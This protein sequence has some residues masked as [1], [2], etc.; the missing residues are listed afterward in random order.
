MRGSDMRPYRIHYTNEDGEKRV[1][2]IAETD[3]H[4][5]IVDFLLRTGNQRECITQ[6]DVEIHHKWV[7]VQ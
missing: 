1:Y 6:V 4:G 3:V 5:A 2:H 7:K